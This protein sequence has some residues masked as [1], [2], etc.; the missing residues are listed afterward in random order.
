MKSSIPLI[1]FLTLILSKSVDCVAQSAPEIPRG[2]VEIS[3]AIPPSPDAASLGKFGSIPVSPSTGIPNIS[4]PLY[5]IKSGDLSLPISLAYHSGGLKTEEIASSVGLGWTLNAGGAITRTIRGKA[6][7]EYLGFLDPNHFVP[8]IDSTLNGFNNYSQADLNRNLNAIADG[9]IDGEPDIYNFNFGTYSGRF[10]MDSYGRCMSIPQSKIKFSFQMD[11]GIDINSFSAITPDGVKYDF[12]R[13]ADGAIA[14][15]KTRTNTSCTPGSDKKDYTTSWFLNKITSPNGYVIRFDYKRESYT[16]SQPRSITK[17]QVIG[18]PSGTYETGIQPLPPEES[19][20]I[21]NTFFTSKL[22]SISFDQGTLI[23][24]ADSI[25][26]DINGGSTLINSI[27][28]IGTNFTKRFKFCYTNKYNTRLRLDSLYDDSDQ[29]KIE[30]YEFIY[31]PD[32]WTPNTLYSQ[33]YWGYYNG[34]GNNTLVPAM[35]LYI[36]NSPSPL[37][38]TGAERKTNANVMQGGILTKIIYPTGG[39]TTFQYEANQEYNLDM[40]GES[41]QYPSTGYMTAFSND[42]NSQYYQYDVINDN[43]NHNMHLV[44]STK[45]SSAIFLHA[46]G[47]SGL[48]SHTTTNFIKGTIMRVQSGIS[49]NVYNITNVD[50]T[51]Y[52]PNGSYQIVINDNKNQAYSESNP[53]GFKYEVAAR[54]YIADSSVIHNY[55]VGGLRIKQ[56]TDYDGTKTLPVQ[57][58]TYKYTLAGQN[59]SSGWLDYRPIYSYYYRTY[60]GASTQSYGGYFDYF[61]RTSISN[62][63]LATTGGSVVGYSHVEEFLGLNGENGKNE[64]FFTNSQSAP[65]LSNGVDFPFAPPVSLDWKRGLLLKELNYKKS[66]EVGFVKIKEKINTYSSTPYTFYIGIKAGFNPMPANYN[67][68]LPYYTHTITDGTL[69][70]KTY[71]GSTDFTFL[72]TDTTRLYN[73]NDLTQYVQTSNSY[74]YDPVSLQIAKII[75]S[76]SSNEKIIQTVKY[77]GNYTISA[78]PTDPALKGLKNL[79]DKSII[80]APVEIVTQKSSSSGTNL[81]TVSSVLNTYKFNQPAKDTVFTLQTINAITDFS[82]SFAG[83]KLVKDNRYTAALSFDKYDNWGNILQEKKIKGSPTSYIWGY[84]SLQS[85]FNPTFP[86]AEVL[87]ADYIN[88]AYTNFESYPVNGNSFGNWVYNSTGIVTDHT[89]P[90]GPECFSVS[91]TNSI[92]K[93]G[94]NLSKYILSYWSSPGSVI[95]FIGG[96]NNA[97]QASILNG[98][99]YNEYLISNVSDL[100]ISG[101]GKID[102]LRLYPVEAQMNTYTYTPLVGILNKCDEKSLITHYDY[103]IKGR[104]LNIKDQNFNIIKNLNYNFRYVPFYNVAKSGNFRKNCGIGYAPGPPVPYIVEARKHSAST[105]TEADAL[106]L[107]DLNINGQLIANQIGTCGPTINSVI[108]N[109][110][111][112]VNDYKETISSSYS[113][114][115]G[116]QSVSV[117]YNNVTISMNLSLAS[118]PIY[119]YSADGSGYLHA[120]VAG[121]AEI[122]LIVVDGGKIQIGG[123]LSVNLEQL[124]EQLRI[125]PK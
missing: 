31:N 13:D 20:Y 97:P 61:V 70:K 7:E 123:N 25:R 12:G 55:V 18:I 92:S 88:V 35:M 109:Q 101:A 122:A 62:Y 89:A 23:V 16:V 111:N 81:R 39:Y 37:Y 45:N 40:G 119:L 59:S 116:G 44:Y 106:A 75:S 85:P 60:H 72:E 93:S 104:L 64:Y 95:S 47:L 42:P 82:Y 80:T 30:K 14:V 112:K 58:K 83:A 65:D 71:S 114:L 52:L 46:S 76:N 73:S 24:N 54:W 53:Y 113:S 43:L 15:E 27:R 29:S 87:N 96:V 102:E 115:S 22:T 90:M 34:Y 6:D 110:T 103:D 117:L 86:V 79:Q 2:G 124:L 10:V 3:K 120:T 49:T 32:Y 56:I 38:L 99:R 57:L 4:I 108:T 51:I 78:S 48:N 21:S 8:K 26:R 63:P 11:Q 94:L 98:W 28:I 84:Y 74:Q 50:T 33:D 41:N 66:P 105:Q 69:L 67:Q 17:Y 121:G 107:N 5:T 1:I 100:T 77:S 36:S 91:S 9:T 118:T 19:C 125:I 68:D